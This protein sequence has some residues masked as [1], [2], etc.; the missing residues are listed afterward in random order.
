MAWMGI[1]HNIKYI[2]QFV[3]TSEFYKTT[4]TARIPQ[5]TELDVIY[6]GVEIQKYASNRYPADPTIGFFYRMNRE[7]GLDIL[8]EAFVKLKKRNTVKN[9]RLKVAGGYTAK[10]RRFL[11]GVK[12]TLQPFMDD[13]DWCSVYDPE[14][15]ADFYRQISIISVPI[16]FDEGV[17]LYLCEAFAAGRPAV[18]PAT[19]SFPE[20]IA[21]AGIVYS[22]SNSDAL[23]NAIEKILSGETLFRHCCEHALKISQTRYNHE[24]M[25]KRLVTVYEKLNLAKNHQ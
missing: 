15:H 22:P 5:I 4:I 7:N 20:I 25:A 23:A 10:D 9:L 16:T 11:R 19:G 24:V 14:L 21:D 18:E 17:G 2:D 8:A 13:V 6:P 1:T 12:K 3:T